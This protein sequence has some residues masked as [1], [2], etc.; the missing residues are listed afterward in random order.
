M[1]HILIVDDSAADCQLAGHLLEG[2]GSTV[3]YAQDG[4]EALVQLQEHPLD[5][6]LTDLVMPRLDGLALVERMKAEHPRVPVVLMT[7]RG[8]EEIA[9]QALESGAASYVPKKR[10]VR[11]LVE[12]I[13]RV[14]DASKEH[15]SH[16]RLLGRMRAASFE[17]ENDL[18]LVAS[19]VSYLTQV[20]RD[21]EMFNEADCHRVATALDEAL[22]NACCHGNLE[23]ESGLREHDPKA[24]QAMTIARR[25]VMP[26]RDRRIQVSTNLTAGQARFVIRD[27]GRGFDPEALPD[28]TSAE[29]LERAS[30]RGVLLMK[31]FMDGVHYNK[32]GNEVTL[33]KLRSA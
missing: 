31:A 7:A 26:Y 15:K 32:T 18:D 20:L 8:S 19:L 3:F 13:T 30:G 10:L 25:D 9:V 17:L 2:D 16:R 5:L 1:A 33:L 12:T 24:Y 28:P 27:D 4:E 21:S 23:V 14:L 6:V 22:S 29:S 11:S